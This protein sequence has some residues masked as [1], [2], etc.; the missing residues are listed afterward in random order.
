M[1]HSSSNPI[2]VFSG[3]GFQNHWGSKWNQSFAQFQWSPSFKIIDSNL[4]IQSQRIQTP[5]S[6]SKA[7]ISAVTLGFLQK[8][9]PNVHTFLKCTDIS[10]TYL[11]A[12]E[13]ADQHVKVEDYNL[14]LNTQIPVSETITA[15]IRYDNINQQPQEVLGVHLDKFGNHHRLGLWVGADRM[16][17]YPSIDWLFIHPLG[18]KIDIFVSNEPYLKSDEITDLVR[19]NPFQHIEGLHKNDIQEKAIINSKAGLEFHSM[20]HLS[21]SHQVQYRLDMPIYV[22]FPSSLYGRVMDDFLVQTTEFKIGYGIDNFIIQNTLKYNQYR[23]DNLDTNWLPYSGNWQET[24][25]AN[26]H[27]LL[28]TTALNGSVESERRDHFGE[29]LPNAFLLNLTHEISI[30]GNIKIN[31]KLLNLLDK[32]YILFAGVPYQPLNASIG[33]T[34]TF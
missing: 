5:L 25:S 17:I 9:D 15:S 8:I 18:H 23:C 10:L 28:G 32:H 13:D 27:H 1:Y 29:L 4:N 33:A 6:K 11:Y 24:V 31:A 3:D 20:F 12:K 14:L 30:N 26:Y 34:V 16:H 22:N 21:F 19:I 2:L 7:E